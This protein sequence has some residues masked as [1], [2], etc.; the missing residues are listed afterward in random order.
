MLVPL[1]LQQCEKYAFFGQKKTNLPIKSWEIDKVENF[2]EKKSCNKLFSDQIRGFVEK[3]IFDDFM[4][5]PA[6]GGV[7]RTS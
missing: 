6:G 4:S 5:C 2:F 7:R 3:V 1:N